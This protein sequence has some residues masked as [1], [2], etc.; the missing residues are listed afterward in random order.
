VTFLAPGALALLLLAIPI[1]LL[2]M[3]RL[4]RQTAP[5]SS[6]LLWRLGQ[7]DRQANQPWQRLKPS[8]LLLTQ[9]LTLVALSLALAR[10]TLARQQL[11]TDHAVLLLD[12]SASMRAVDGS[13]GAASRFAL[14]QTAALTLLDSMPTG[15]RVTLIQVGRAPRVVAASTPDRAAAA[16]RL[17]GLEPEWGRADWP[18][19]LALAAGALTDPDAAAFILSDGGLPADGLP[20]LAGDVRYVLVG[21]PAANL[22]VAAF[23]ATGAAAG[24]PQVF[25]RIDNTGAAAEVLLSLYADGDL[26]E[27]R[28][29]TVPAAGS[30]PLVVAAPDA[31]RFEA[32]LLPADGSAARLDALAA[33]DRAFAVRAAGGARSVLL[34][35]YQITP[36]VRHNLFLRQALTAL[37]GPEN[38]TLLQPGPDGAL[39]LPTD[40]PALLVLD[41]DLLA[42]PPGPNLLLVN[43]PTSE[44]LAVGAPFTNTAPVILADSPLTR[45][46]RWETVHLLAARTVTPPPWAQP[47]IVAPGGP[48]L[49]AG[50][51]GGRRVAALL[52][53]LHASDLPLQLDFPIL[54]ANLTAWLLGEGDPLGGGAWTVG[55]LVTPPL[56]ASGGQLEVT[57]PEGRAVRRDAGTAFAVT[58]PGWWLVRDPAAPESE[59]ALAVN[60]FAPEE[61]AL[62][63]LTELRVGGTAQPAAPPTPARR[64]LWPLAALLALLGLAVEWWLYRGGPRLRRVE[65]V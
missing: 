19:A 8:A 28:R 34:T 9:L 23:S 5:V 22:S 17:R 41:G 15:A 21:A 62:P 6:T 43:P 30:L 12:A 52:F 27:A 40:L 51:T 64:E 53:D 25:V 7:L 11:Q 14:A 4:R 55:D 3:L 10:P 47:L 60:L 44:L 65:A 36:T 32:R 61:S 35:P 50:E 16:D 1:V 48:L 37:V 29:L 57:P 45:D 56:T 63:R 24:P 39:A 54:L 18:A 13:A 49:L 33:D 26:F 59:T 46:L 58:R 31:R 2:H 38:L 20:A 42:P